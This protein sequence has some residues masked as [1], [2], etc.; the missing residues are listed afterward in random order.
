MKTSGQRNERRAAVRI[1]MFAIGSTG[2]V[3]PYCLLGRELKRRGQEITIA[4]FAPFEDMV[5]KAGL[6]FS[7]LRA[8]WRI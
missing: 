7:P 8:T 6:A 5:T 1:T 2:D 3:R 4:A